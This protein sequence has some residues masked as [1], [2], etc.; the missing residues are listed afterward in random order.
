MHPGKQFVRLG[1]HDGER[2]QAV[3]FPV[4]LGIPQGLRTPAGSHSPVR[5]G[6][7]ACPLSPLVKTRRRDQTASLPERLT[8]RRRFRDGLGTRVNRR[9]KP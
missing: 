7:A 5:T 3:S 2:L 9:Q 4:F 8:S 1:C 6:T